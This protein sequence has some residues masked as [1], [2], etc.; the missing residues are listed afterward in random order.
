MATFRQFEDI[1]AWQKA[2]EL[3]ARL[4]QVSMAGDFSRDFAMKDQMR[5]A[6]L[7]IPSN[8]AEGFERGVARSSSSSS[9]MPKV[10]AANCALNF[11]TLWTKPTSTN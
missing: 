9:V 2:R 6:S 8:I 4:Y 7:S 5:R 11:T 1:L 3:V 10:L